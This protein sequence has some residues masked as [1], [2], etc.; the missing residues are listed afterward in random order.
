MTVASQ[1]EINTELEMC[2]KL[3]A[4]GFVEASLGRVLAIAQAERR[5]RMVSI[6][7]AGHARVSARRELAELCESQTACEEDGPAPI[8]GLTKAQ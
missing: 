8:A 6:L 3:D 4:L 5:Q 2:A 7:A 1:G